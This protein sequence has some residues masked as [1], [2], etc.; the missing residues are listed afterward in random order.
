MI[1]QSTHQP[2]SKEVARG[3]P[4]LAT[5]IALVCIAVLLS[6]VAA[7]LSEAHD[8]EVIQARREAYTAGRSQALADMQD[9]PQSPVV[10]EACIAWWFNPTAT[11]KR[12]ALQRAC[13]AQAER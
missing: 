7:N 11:D 13:K 5:A 12:T 4:A 10:A 8:E 2:W 9:N 6:L 3:L 1:K